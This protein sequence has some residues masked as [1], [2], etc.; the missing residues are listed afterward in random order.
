MEITLS[1]YCIARRIYIYIII[2][3]SL[4]VKLPTIWTDEK[5]RWAE[6]ERRD[7]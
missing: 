5:Q 4:E 6:A 1:R 2:E 7:E 3:G